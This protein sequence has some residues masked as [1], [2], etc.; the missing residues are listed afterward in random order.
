MTRINQDSVLI[1]FI[2]AFFRVIR[3]PFCS[4]PSYFFAISSNSF[5]VNRTLMMYGGWPFDQCP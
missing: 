1:L 3:V 2:P 4:S 5:S